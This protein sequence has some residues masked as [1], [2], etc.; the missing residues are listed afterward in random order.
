MGTAEAVQV[1]PVTVVGGGGVDER[2][3]SA[4]VQSSVPG[5][6]GQ[7]VN[8]ASSP[9]ERARPRSRMASP[10]GGDHAMFLDGLTSR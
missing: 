7:R 6:Q 5:R 4:D 2:H 1:A 3:C 8:G 9:V 10:S